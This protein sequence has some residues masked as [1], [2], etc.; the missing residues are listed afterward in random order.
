MICFGEVRA[1]FSLCFSINEK[2][3]VPCAHET[4]SVGYKPTTTRH[5]DRIVRISA[6]KISSHQQILKELDFPVTT[7]AGSDRSN[8]T[9]SKRNAGKDAANESRKTTYFSGENIGEVEEDGIEQET[10]HV[11]LNKNIE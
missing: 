8:R 3:F 7:A 1:I 10:I 5:E 2:T 6:E 9:E 4:F 11:R